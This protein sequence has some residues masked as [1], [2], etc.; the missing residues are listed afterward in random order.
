MKLRE[1]L[2]SA[3]TKLVA[4]GGELKED[5]GKIK[6]Q[7]RKAKKQIKKRREQYGRF[8]AGATKKARK[9]RKALRKTQIKA[10]KASKFLADFDTL[11]DTTAADYLGTGFDVQPLFSQPKP[12]RKRGKK[13]R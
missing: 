5:Y 6:V 10:R 12:R 13:K 1:R 8:K 9:T 3:K 4:F 7:H 2:R 11:L